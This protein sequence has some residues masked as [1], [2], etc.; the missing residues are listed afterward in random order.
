MIQNKKKLNCALYMCRICDIIKR[1]KKNVNYS[2]EFTSSYLNK[3]VS[4]GW[5]M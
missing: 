5:I 2:Y 1:E 3:I 4:F